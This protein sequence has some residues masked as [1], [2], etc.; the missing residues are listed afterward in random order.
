MKEVEFHVGSTVIAGLDNQVQGDIII[1]LHGFLDNAVSLRPLAP[2]LDNYRFIILDLAGHGKSSHRPLSAHYNQVDYLQDLFAILTDNDWKSVTLLG[3]SLGGIL[4]TLFAGMFPEYSKGVISLDSCGPLTKPEDTTAQQMRE[5]VLSRYEK[6]R[7]RLRMVDLNTAVE[8]R[9]KVTDTRPQD[10]RKIIQRN[11]TQDASGHCFWSSDPRLRT[12][13]TVRLTEGQ[14]E[15]IMRQIDCPVLFTSAST[16]F[17][18][19]DAV[20]SERKQWFKQS[21]CVAFDGGHHVHMEKP[22]EIGPVIREF[23]DQL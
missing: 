21:Q 11:L 4:C 6:S 17:K 12:R 10:A 18:Q 7:N 15:N 19:V 5:S 13:S 2:Y 3:H 16:S 9:C 20:Y 23:V 14:A 1:G 22:D 8:A